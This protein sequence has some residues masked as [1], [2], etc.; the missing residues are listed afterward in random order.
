MRSCPQCRSRFGEEYFFCLNDGVRLIDDA[1]EQITF[2]APAIMRQACPKCGGGN[3]ADAVFCSKCGATMS[4]PSVVTA[5]ARPL[6]QAPAKNADLLPA[7]LADVDDEPVSEGRSRLV[8][9][10][11]LAAITILGLV[12][13]AMLIENG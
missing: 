2:V 6:I 3:D 4:V 13:I 10:L 11:V 7:F 8:N 1:G 5:A 9:F 12:F